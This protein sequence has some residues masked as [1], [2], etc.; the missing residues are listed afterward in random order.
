[1][2]YKTVT[3]ED[4]DKAG[5]YAINKAKGI[6]GKIKRGQTLENY[7]KLAIINA[8]QTRGEEKE[9]GIGDNVFF[10]RYENVSE[11]KQIKKIRTSFPGKVIKFYYDGVQIMCDMFDDY[12]QV[13]YKD[14][15]VI[16][17]EEEV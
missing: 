4:V 1:M 12:V 13:P 7:F 10:L 6:R 11:G 9:L 3:Q 16:I 5:E 17:K 15:F 8:T 14:I 2:K